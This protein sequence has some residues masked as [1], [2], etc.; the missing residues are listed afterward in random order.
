M[1]CLLTDR[2]MVTISLPLHISMNAC[3]NLE[4]QAN[5]QAPDRGQAIVF[6]PDLHNAEPME[7]PL[8][9]LESRQHRLVIPIGGI[10]Q[11][12]AYDLDAHLLA[13]VDQ[14]STWEAVRGISIEGHTDSGGSEQ[15]NKLLSLRRAN[16]VAERL[17]E[18]G[19][20]SGLMGGE[21]WGESRPVADNT[22]MDG[23]VANRRVEIIVT[24][25]PQHSAVA[26]TQ[27]AGG[28]LP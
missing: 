11:R 20:E 1:T 8:P 14:L 18:L 12:R 19:V 24:G 16:V 15:S 13:L 23:R 17:E 4:G 7:Q 21:A 5:A 6:R 28:D 3:Q 25:Y 22:T 2:W 10:G 27:L 9:V 26:L